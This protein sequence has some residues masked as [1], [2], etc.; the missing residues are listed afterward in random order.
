[1]SNELGVPESGNR[2]E[3]LEG[4]DYDAVVHGIVS[5]GLQPVEYKGEK[6]QPQVFLRVI[7]ELP[8]VVREDGTTATTG[9][10]IKVTDSVDKGN[11][12]KF[13]LALGEKVTESNIRSYFSSEALKSLLGRYVVASVE[14][15]ESD[16]GTAASIKEFIKF[17]PN[18]PKPM[19]KRETFYFNPLTPD[20]K[21]FEN[22]LSYRTQKDVMSALNANNF[23]PQLHEL[24][25]K[26]QVEREEKQKENNN[27]DNNT[28]PWEEKN[29]NFS[30]A[31][32]E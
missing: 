1:M 12:A 30:A 27:K 6:K 9:K 4:K 29:S 16:T 5:L 20:L 25:E 21:V 18:A 32:I 24:W 8:D 22:N 19:P 15:W 17:H 23:P 28:P 26:I 10:R 13:L 14:Q 2:Y 3:V 7:V 31:S 11:F